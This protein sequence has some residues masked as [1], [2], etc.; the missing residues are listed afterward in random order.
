MTHILIV[1]DEE[2]LS[3]PLAYILQREGYQVS[4]A[5]DG[6]AAV[7]AFD[8][9][10]ADLV[11]LDLMLPGIPG[12]EVCRVIRTKSQVPIVML[13]AKD[14]EVDI[15]VGLE[16]GADDYVTKPYSTRELLARIRAVL[17]RRVDPDDLSDS[18]LEAGDIRMD[19]ERHVVT[20]RGD[21]VAMPLKEFELLELLMR[22][23]GRVLTRGQLIDRVW[24]SDYF[25]D[26]KTLD[27]HIKRIRSK[28]EAVP[29]EP[30][31]LVTVRGL[32]YRIEA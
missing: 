12:T 32:G 27:V 17:R 20:V 23:A 25:G 2:S 9:T 28:I 4:V 15:V 13:T 24:G 19:V 21:D 16:L 3:E 18:M 30:K 29:S 11:L 31:A 26:T 1:E 14:S 22:N 6:P 10:G 5:E 8:K 7:T